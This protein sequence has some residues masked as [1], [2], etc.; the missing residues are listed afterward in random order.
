LMKFT[1]NWLLGK[2]RMLAS[3]IQRPNGTISMTND[4]FSRP[5]DL[6]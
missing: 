1:Q 5:N 2:S 3:L 4:R 6:L